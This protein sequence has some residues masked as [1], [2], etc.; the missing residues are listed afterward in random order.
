MKNTFLDDD[1]STEEAIGKMVI[2]ILSVVVE[3]EGLRILERI[4]EDRIEA[5]FKG[6]KFWS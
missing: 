4:N 1:I 2:S 6:I 3:A 5:K